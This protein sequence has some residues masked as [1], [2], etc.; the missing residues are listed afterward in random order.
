MRTIKNR[1]LISLRSYLKTFLEK[2]P[3]RELQNQE[4]ETY[5]TPGENGILFFKRVKGFPPSHFLEMYIS[6]R[7]CLHKRHREKKKFSLLLPSLPASGLV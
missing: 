4:I 3:I 5:K 6:Q 1:Q 7:Q 2:Y